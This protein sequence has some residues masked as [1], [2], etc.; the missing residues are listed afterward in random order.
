MTAEDLGWGWFDADEKRRN[1]PRK[2][3]QELLRIF[4]KCFRGSHGDQ[5]LEHLRAI[6]LGRALGPHCSDELLRHVEG[7]RQLVAYITSL[8][9]RAHA[10]PT[11][12]HVGEIGHDINGE[13][14]EDER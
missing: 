12:K 2:D 4:G 13:Y 5:A 14:I 9:K 7:Q 3:E 6:T 1:E 8:V 11:G 10:E